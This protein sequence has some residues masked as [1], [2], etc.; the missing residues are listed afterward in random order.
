MALE[1]MRHPI[2]SGCPDGF[3]YMHPTMRKNYG[4]WK[5][6]E[7]PRPGVLRHVAHSGDEIWTVKCGTQR[8]LDVFSLRKLTSIGDEFADGYVRFTIRS[9]IEYMVT[10]EAQVEPL[11]KALTDAGF[12]VGGTAN[13]VAMISHTQGWL[14]CD[15]PG[16]DASGVVKSMMDE[17]ID[18]F[19]PDALHVG[20]D[21]VFLIASD[22]CPRCRGREPAKLFAKAV[23]DYHSHLVGKR[24]LTMLMWGDRLLDD[25]RMHYD[26]WEAS[27]NGTAPAIDMIPKDIIIRSVA[28]ASA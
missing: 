28:W 4:A 7:H 22:Q 17:L 27:R 13:S 2:E 20:M 3:Q 5:F 21:E 15:I 10:K 8:I 24:K 25:S 26:E 12:I 23:N 6:H 19:R 1:D 11:I 16:T 18:A 9:N 14:H